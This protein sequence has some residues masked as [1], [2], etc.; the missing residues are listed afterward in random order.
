MME[1]ALP[2]YT[3]ITYRPVLKLFVCF[4]Y[5]DQF[6]RNISK[7]LVSHLTYELVSFK[8]NT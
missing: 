8:Y 3:N 7:T 2:E 1:K 6:K 4:V 5:F